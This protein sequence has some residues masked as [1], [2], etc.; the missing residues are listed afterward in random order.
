M[1]G[2]LS[3][4]FSL[5]AKANYT[6]VLWVTLISIPAGLSDVY[7]QEVEMYIEN[8]TAYR[9]KGR[10]AVYFSHENHMDAYECLRCHHDFKNGKNVLNETG[11]KE[12]G[13][14]GCANCHL[15][16]P[17]IGLKKAYHRQCIGCH[18]LLDKRQADTL[19]LTCQD[20]HPK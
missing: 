2:S 3:K 10:P 4:T 7:P 18:R 15:D 19:P 16:T 17:S 8:A 5:V 13:A 20:C 6:I 1:T 14:V 9:N 11:L 12:N